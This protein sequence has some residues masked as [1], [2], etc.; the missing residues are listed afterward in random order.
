VELG[1]ALFF[2]TVGVLLVVRLALRFQRRKA[3]TLIASLQNL[4][5]NECVYALRYQHF[6]V[7]TSALTPAQMIDLLKNQH[8][9]SIERIRLVVAILLSFVV[10]TAALYVILLEKHSNESQKWAF[11]A[12]GTIIGYWL[13]A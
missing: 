11:G 7:D 3:E 5:N 1:L 12:V 9:Q 13:K 2:L 6:N 10:L 4:P 8:E